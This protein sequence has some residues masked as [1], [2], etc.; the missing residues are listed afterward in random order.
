MKQLFIINQHSRANIYGIGTYTQ[1]LVRSVKN[2]FQITVVYLNDD[3]HT[4]FFRKKQDNVEY[5]YFP[6]PQYSGADKNYKKLQQY[7]DRNVFYLLKPY[8]LLSG[9]NEKLFHFNFFGAPYLIE[10]LKGSFKCK[11][12][13]TVH[14]MIWSFDLLGDFGK[15]KKIMQNPENQEEKRI[16]ESVEFEKCFINDYCDKVITIARHSYDTL[17][18]IYSIPES[19]MICIYNGLED[20]YEELSAVEIRKLRSQYYFNQNDKIIL[21]A[22][23]LDPVK[24]LSFLISA[25]KELMEKDSTVRLLIIGDGD[26]KKYFQE[27]TSFWSRVTFTGFIDK[28]HLYNLYRIAD[29]GVL[30]SLH[31]E[32][33]YVALE[34]MMQEL[35]LV[36]GRTTG[37]AELVVNGK[38]GITVQMT[39]SDTVSEFVSAILSLLDNAFLRNLYKQNARERYLLNYS[40]S[41]FYYRMNNLY[42]HLNEFVCK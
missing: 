14:Y 4:Y 25:F 23:R 20:C 10:L 11:V 32:F 36:V 8:L 2:I 18:D 12:V 9:N 34:M 31:E 13:L 42:S 3:T 38:T 26:I 30:P 19:K 28:K 41:E 6:T 7:Y 15:L 24:G 16:K 5:L 40:L 21:F 37:L 1:Q 27:T 39:A 35:P 33:G 17:R 22:G 29:I